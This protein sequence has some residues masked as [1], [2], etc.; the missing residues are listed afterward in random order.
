M[1]PT[2][3]GYES[4]GSEASDAEQ[5][6][7]AR[8]FMIS[9]PESASLPRCTDALVSYLEEQA[10]KGSKKE[11]QILDRM[12]YTLASRRTIYS[13]RTAVT[14]SSVNELI[15]NLKAQKTG[16]RAAKQPR[17]LFIF[18]GQGAQWATM[19]LGLMRHKVFASSV[20]KADKYM[21]SLG[22]DW[23]V[24][25]ELAASAEQSHIAMAKFSQPLCT[26]LQ[27]ALVD[28]LKFWGVEASAVVGH[29]SGE[30]GA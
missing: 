30:I 1:L 20:W 28:L 27:V 12:A 10:L 11:E 9:A 22:A 6:K 7:A 23:R 21:T 17:L 18:T 13:W 29:S 19:G 26:V 8:L 16:K 3:E 24:F 4:P 5:S 15:A 2:D 14:A 25:E